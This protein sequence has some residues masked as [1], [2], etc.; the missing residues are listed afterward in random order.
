MHDI[1]PVPRQLGT[2]PLAA[3]HGIGAA[4]DLQSGALLGFAV[5]CLAAVAARDASD[6]AG[7]TAHCPPRLT[8]LASSRSRGYPIAAAPR[9]HWPAS[10]RRSEPP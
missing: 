5:L 9:P 7:S 4:A 1:G 10:S 2:S 3:N 6:A 8:S